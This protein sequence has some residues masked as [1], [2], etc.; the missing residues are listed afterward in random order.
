MKMSHRCPAPSTGN[1]ERQPRQET[2]DEAARLATFYLR[3]CVKYA[4]SRQS[5]EN[6]DKEVK[7]RNMQSQRAAF[8]QLT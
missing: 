3:A 5:T 1:T 2:W 7:R 4:A 6:W 8:A